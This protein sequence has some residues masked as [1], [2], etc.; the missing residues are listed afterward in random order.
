[1]RRLIPAAT[2]K[3]VFTKSGYRCAFPNCKAQLTTESGTFLGEIA[4]ILA[5]YAGGPRYDSTIPNNGNTEE[6]LILLCPTHHAL[7]DREPTNYHVEW[8]KNVKAAH[9]LRIAGEAKTAL[10][11]IDVKTISTFHES[12]EFWNDNRQNHD[13]EVWQSFF[14]A[15]PFV[16]SQ[17]VPDHIIKLGGKCYVGGKSIANT[18]GNIIDFLF[19]TK[20]AKNVVLI[21]IKHP[22]TKL[23]GKQYRTNAFSMSDALSGSIVQVL[24]YRD[25]LLKNYFS[26]IGQNPDLEFTAFNP[27]CIVLAGD[28]DRENPNTNQRR[29]LELFRN[30]LSNVRVLSYDELFGKVKD[31]VDIFT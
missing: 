18:G 1:M 14:A 27:Q 23:I 11:D 16:L 2:K 28:L 7:V 3:A 8:L 21:E 31:L 5:V 22:G 17:A 15:N 4:H 25:D 30:S 29:S 20:I 24:N 13:E 19:T 26:L 12:L 6:N 9:E 10:P